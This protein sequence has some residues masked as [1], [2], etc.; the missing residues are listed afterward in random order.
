MKQFIAYWQKPIFPS[1]SSANVIMS[2]T[3]ML[4]I[5][6]LLAALA[7]VFQSAGGFVPG[8]G[9]LISPFSTLPIVVA[10]CISM[11]SGFFT[12]VA[13]IGLL[14]MLQPGELFIFPF[15]TGLLGLAIGLS[16]KIV[17]RRLP[18]VLLSGTVL[19]LG[20]SFVAFV[21]QFP[22][23]GPRSALG[24]AILS[25]VLIFS[26]FYSYFWVEISRLFLQRIFPILK[27]R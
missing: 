5:S 17:K 12:Y 22:L 19:F 23:F 15:T 21:L 18:V 26:L 2:R 4:I 27:H 7:A 1:A 20:I 14:F 13:A 6:A 11:T 3:H 9:Y 24:P 25:I 10:A 16:I 8:I